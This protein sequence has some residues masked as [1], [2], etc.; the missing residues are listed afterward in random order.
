[1]V[2]SHYAHTFYTKDPTYIVYRPCYS[3][4]VVG[5][6]LGSL[7]TSVRLNKANAIFPFPVGMVP[8]SWLRYIETIP[9]RDKAILLAVLIC[10]ILEQNLFLK[11]IFS[12]I[13]NPQYPI[14]LCR[15][16]QT[17]RMLLSGGREGPF[18]GRQDTA[19]TV[20]QGS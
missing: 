12:W 3:P 13:C 9:K 4:P 10:S 17:Y 8:V 11:I 2:F 5:K 19:E 18:S 7:I 16:G 20:F 14:L 6:Y 15:F 1:M